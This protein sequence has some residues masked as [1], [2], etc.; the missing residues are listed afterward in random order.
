[1]DFDDD[2]IVMHFPARVI[3]KFLDMTVFIIVC[4]LNEGK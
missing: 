4:G 3:I 2:Q 1:M